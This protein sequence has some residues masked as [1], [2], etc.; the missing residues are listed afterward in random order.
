MFAVAHPP[1]L[2][3]GTEGVT[4]ALHGIVFRHFRFRDHAAIRHFPGRR[5]IQVVALV[6]D[7][8][9]ALDHQ[10]LQA[11]FAQFLGDPASADPGTDDNGIEIHGIPC[12]QTAVARPIS[13]KGTQ[14]RHAPGTSS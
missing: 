4:L 3:G 12:A 9:A 13:E 11:A 7:V 6:I 5:E 8:S 2:G 14:A 10:R 1:L